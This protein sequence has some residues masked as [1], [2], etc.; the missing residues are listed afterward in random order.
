M[1]E[2]HFEEDAFEEGRKWGQMIGFW[3]LS[4]ALGSS[5]VCFALFAG[6]VEGSGDGEERWQGKETEG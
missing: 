3:L 2:Q 1:M 6:V 4:S 5:S